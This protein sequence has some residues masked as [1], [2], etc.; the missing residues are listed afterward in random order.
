MV[1]ILDNSSGREVITSLRSLIKD[2]E[3]AQFAVGYFY[4][5]G[6]NLFKNVLPD[7]PPESFL[8]ILIGRELNFP[9]FKE[10]SKGYKL[11]VK[12]DFL[13]DLSEISE[14]EISNVY[15]LYRLIKNRIVDFKIYLEGTLHSKLY[16]F[17]ENA[18]PL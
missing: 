17:I 3:L 7:N 10:I 5:S 15:E 14:E 1:K 8:Q 9:T 11:R 18:N 4:L 12:T 6:W 13:D 2:S 16:L